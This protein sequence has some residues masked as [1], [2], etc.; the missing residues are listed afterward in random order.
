[1]VLFDTDEAV[2]Q[3][4]LRVLGNLKLDLDTY[5]MSVAGRPV[6]TTY[7]ELELLRLLLDQPGRIIDYT[8]ITQ[9]LWGA[10]D[11]GALRHLNVLVH[12]LRAKLADSSPYSI[13][14]VRGRGYGLLKT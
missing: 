6:E 5:R 3:D 10:A 8:E 2:S 14:T 1:M 7:Y 11:R 9:T 13:E 4:G 12:R